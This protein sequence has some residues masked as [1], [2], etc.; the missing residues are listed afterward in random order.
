MSASTAAT[1]MTVTGPLY[2]ATPVPAYR[3][4][5]ETDR[6]VTISPP[7]T[8]DSIRDAIEQESWFT[9]WMGEF[10]QLTA[11]YFSK[12]YTAQQVK[13]ITLHV[14]PDLTEECPYVL[15]PRTVTF[16]G[17]KCEVEWAGSAVPMVIDIPD[18]D[19]PLPT[20][21]APSMVTA[22]EELEEVDDASLPMANATDTRLQDRQRLKEARLK[23]KI[24]LYRVQHQMAL[25]QDRY[26]MSATESESDS[27]SEG[28]DTL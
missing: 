27:E 12:A 20:V 21:P 19:D 3:F 5:V 1:V 9:A 11:K 18:L 13:R 6:C 4:Q 17:G 26:G 10:L 22:F 24:A 28:Y 8:I 16:R 14:G 23:A 7:F 25:Y 2:A 15:H